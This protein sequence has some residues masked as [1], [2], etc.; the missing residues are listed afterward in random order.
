MVVPLNIKLFIQQNTFFNYLFFHWSKIRKYGRDAHTIT[1]GLWPF[2]LRLTESFGER[3]D[4]DIKKTYTRFL[5][6]IIE[7]L[8]QTGWKLVT[9]QEYNL[10]V[11]FLK[12]LHK[13]NGIS[14]E[15]EDFTIELLLSGHLADEGYQEEGDGEDTDK[16]FEG[17]DAFGQGLA[18]FQPA[19]VAHRCEGHG[20][21]G[22]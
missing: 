13:I 19:A 22:H 21:E 3:F 4:N 6:P 5:L 2:T 15:G 10:L 11:L 17:A 14:L 9:K 16:G 12:L 20:A 7:H 1:S 8:L 18:C